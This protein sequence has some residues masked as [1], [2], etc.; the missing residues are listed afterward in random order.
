MNNSPSNLL[1]R[2]GMALRRLR[3]L[4]RLPRPPGFME[5]KQVEGSSSRMITARLDPHSLALHPRAG[6]LIRKSRKRLRDIIRNTSL[7]RLLSLVASP[8]R[9]RFAFGNLAAEKRDTFP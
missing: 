5:V 7:S 6:I 1:L 3:R 8:R 9:G 2:E 4:R